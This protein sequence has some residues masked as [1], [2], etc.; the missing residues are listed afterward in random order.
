M[1]DLS[2]PTQQATQP[3][4]DPRRRGKTLSNMSDDDISDVICLLHPNS[5]AAFQAVQATILTAPEHILQN[6]DLDGVTEEDLLFNSALQQPREIALRMSSTVHYPKD[7][8][9][10]GRN[11]TL[12]DVLLTGD[13]H[14]KLISNIHFKIFVNSQGSLMLQDLSTNGTILDDEHLKAKDRRG[15]PMPKPA[16]RALKNGAIICVLGG[17]NKTEIKFVVRIPSRGDHEDQ[18]EDKL[19]QYLSVRGKV[20]NFASMRENMY[21]N[22]W[23]GG[24]MYNFT[25]LLGKGAFATVYRVQTKNEGTIFAA[26][27]LDK[28]RFIKNGVLDIKFDSELKIM[29]DLKHPNIV[30]YIDCQTHHNWIYIIM[31]YVPCG[32][33]AK[34]LQDRKNLP[35][36]EV[37]QIAKQIMR[38]LDYLHK[39]NITHRDIKPDNILI[40]SRDPLVVKLSDFGLSKCVNDQETFLKTFCGTL[41]Y[42]APEVYPD[43]GNYTHSPTMKRR[44]LGEPAPKTSPYDQSVDMWSFGAVIFHLLCG[45]APVMGRGDDRGAQMLNNIMTKEIDFEPLRGFNVSP[46]A[47]DF[48]GLLLNRNPHLRPTEQDCLN[49][50]WL[51]GVPDVVEYGEDGEDIVRMHRQM[52]DAVEELDEEDLVD[53]DLMNDLNQLTQHPRSSDPAQSSSPNRPAK[54]QRTFADSM[55]VPGDVAYPVLPEESINVQHPS[56]PHGGALFGEIVNTPIENANVLGQQIGSPGIDIPEIRNRI[57]QVSVNDYASFQ[58]LSSNNRD[59]FLEDIQYQTPLQAPSGREGPAPSLLGAEAQIGLLNMASPEKVQ[60]DAGT[61]ETQNPMT[62]NTRELSPSSSLNKTEEISDSHDSSQEIKFSRRINIELIKDDEAFTESLQAREESRAQKRRL[63][64]ETFHVQPKFDQD[65]K[66]VELAK[67][68]DARTG[69]EVQS[70]HSGTRKVPFSRTIDVRLFKSMN[71]VDQPLTRFGQLT[72][73]PGSFSNE[74]V[75]LDG[76]LTSWG[77]GVDCTVRHSDVKDTRVPKYAVKMT[78]WAPGMEAQVESGSDWTQVP[79]I[80]TYVSTSATSCIWINDVELRRETADGSAALFG[81][82]YTGDVVTVHRGAKS[83]EF[84]SFRVN[85]LFGDS[86]RTRP[87]KESGFFIYR[88][89]YHH[90]IAKARESTRKSSS[91][92]KDSMEEKLAQK[93]MSA[94]GKEPK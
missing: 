6:E 86:A 24:S 88:E 44:R 28:H 17:P 74:P 8:F 5:P 23:N 54:R 59:E 13:Q 81:K 50:P 61:P 40:A 19:R 12:C 3:F 60:S 35:E 66:L 79:G 62:P 67:T 27:E 72:P 15:L 42:C 47:I 51:I 90:R 31:E 38:A 84:L 33:L 39:R 77:R 41:L 26:K 16:M 80:R 2:Q 87:E 45:K 30:D 53:E 92:E 49:H 56:G 58:G 82:I 69:R 71:K 43:Y 89:M 21:G 20:A 75:Y 70:Y 65:F 14:D 18:Y 29:K 55:T 83:G 78:F 7:G 91:V 10:F 68:I 52:L 46:D 32:E 94:M 63:K 34:E 64:A 4:E 57:E 37:Q 76:R 36:Y 9:R 93:S 1:T 25:G 48:I 22:H 11:P 73:L 85:I